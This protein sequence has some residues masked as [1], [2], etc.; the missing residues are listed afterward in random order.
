MKL[1]FSPSSPFARKVRISAIELALIDRIELVPTTVAPTTP[2]EK[3]A[4]HVNPLRKL[5]ALILDNGQ[6]LFDSTVII[7]YLD[8]LAGG[9]KL[10]PAKGPE[11]WQVK[12]ENALIQGMLDAM[13]LAR[14]EKGVRPEAL[15]WPKWIDDQWDRAWHGLKYFEDRPEILSR[16][17]DITQIGLACLL[18]Y[19]DLRFPDSQWREA[20]PKL[21]VFN[22]KMLQRE[23]VKIS[24]PK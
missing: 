12:T 9:G 5:P 15:R 14:Y 20:Y 10:F 13:L 17:F 18:G 2:N 1:T 22:E 11:R 8:D 21:N 19:A 24:V 16:P 3:Y 7:E 6:V 4:D 23:S